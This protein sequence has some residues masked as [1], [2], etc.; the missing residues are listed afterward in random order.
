MSISAVNGV[1]QLDQQR[2]DPQAV[3]PAAASIPFSQQLDAQNSQ[4]AQ[5]GHDAQTGAAHHHRHHSAASQSV[6]SSAATAA[7]AAGVAPSSTIAASLPRL[8]S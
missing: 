8:P 5:T 1:S 4:N 3:T 6:T 2:N 7:S